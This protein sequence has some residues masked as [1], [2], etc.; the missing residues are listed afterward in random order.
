MSLQTGGGTYVFLWKHCSSYMFSCLSV[1]QSVSTWFPLSN[2]KFLMDFFFSNFAYIF[3]LGWVFWDCLWVKSVD[4]WWSYCPCST[5]KMVSS[6]CHENKSPNNTP[7]NIDWHFSQFS[8]E[9]L[10]LFTDRRSFLLNILGKNWWIWFKFH[11]SNYTDNM[12]LGIITLLFI[13][14]YRVPL[15]LWINDIFS[16]KITHNRGWRGMLFNLPP[17]V[18]SHSRVNKVFRQCAELPQPSALQSNVVT[19]WLWH[20]SVIITKMYL[21]KFNPL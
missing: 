14:L 12:L 4:F 17:S 8:T 6:Q 5:T 19:T 10:P 3:I 15:F 18:P 20:L 21:C 11:I 1:R 7:N 2:E 9:L 16:G 13:A